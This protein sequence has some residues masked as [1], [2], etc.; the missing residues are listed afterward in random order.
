M[1]NIQGNKVAWIYNWWQL[2]EGPGQG[3]VGTPFWEYVPML[4][5]DRPDHTNTWFQ[6]VEKCAGVNPA[7]AIHVLSFN[8]PDQCGNGGSC[9][10]DYVQA[11]N[12]HKTWVQPLVD[13]YGSRLYVGT[14]AVTNGVQ[15]P[16]GGPMGLPWLREFMKHCDGC[17]FDYVVIHWYDSSR[18]VEY[19]KKQLQDAWNEFQKPI[20][21]TEFG[22]TGRVDEQLGFLHEV[23]LWMDA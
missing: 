3:P 13:K 20:W 17:K 23:L 12:A 9:M 7:G 1:F 8:E 2:P 18:N 22:A 15:A 10:R 5:S 11:A 6:N 14:P 21:I 16:D 19:F 4:H